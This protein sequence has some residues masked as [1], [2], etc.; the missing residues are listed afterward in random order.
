[1]FFPLAGSQCGVGQGVRRAEQQRAGVLLEHPVALDQ[2]VRGVVDEVLDDLAV[3]DDVEEVV[4]PRPVVVLDVEPSR[5][6]PVRHTRVV[7]LLDDLAL[8]WEDRR[9]IGDVQVVAEEVLQRHGHEIRPAA[10]LQHPD[11]IRV[12]VARDEIERVG[13][14]VDRGG[15]VALFGRPPE[16]LEGG[17]VVH[18]HVAG[19]SR[20]LRADG[21]AASL[22]TAGEGQRGRGPL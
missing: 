1:M 13:E 3:D 12:R 17:E 10:D 15:E 8:A 6:D 5:V 9:F 22:E 20:R 7:G 18:H 4:G 21:H 2:G 11:R 16:V 19:D 14:P